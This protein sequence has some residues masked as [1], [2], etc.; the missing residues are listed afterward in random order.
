MLSRYSLTSILPTVHFLPL[1]SSHT[2][3]LDSLS[4]IFFIR[5]CSPALEFS[6]PTV[7]FRVMVTKR[8]FW[9]FRTRHLEGWTWGPTQPASEIS[10]RSLWSLSFP[11]WKSRARPSVPA[12]T[13]TL[14]FLY[15]LL[16]GFYLPVMFVTVLPPKMSFFPERHTETINRIF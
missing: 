15:A 16:D 1:S 4:G 14:W 7:S 13:K 10:S 12:R 8:T 11:I 6:W 9:V 2:Y 5:E 3:T